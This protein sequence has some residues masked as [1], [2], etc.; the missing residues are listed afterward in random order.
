MSRFLIRW[1]V[2]LVAVYLVVCYLVAAF[3]SVDIWCQAYYLP[4]ELCVCLCISKQGVYH[5]KY[6]KW[7]A[8]AFFFEECVAYL[9]VFFNILPDSYMATVALTII[10]A[11]LCTTVTLAVRHY[12]RVRKI[13]RA[14]EKSR[15]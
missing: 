2:V 6:I 8:Y 1:T 11:G 9:D 10:T 13:K 15:G 14:W 7:T 3:M 4:I 12:I 5:C